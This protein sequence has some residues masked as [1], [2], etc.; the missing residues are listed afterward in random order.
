MESV[1]QTLVQREK[2]N[3][4][5]VQICWST[6][7]IK[8]RDD[9]IVDKKEAEEV[10]QKV[11]G[12]VSA[13]MAKALEIYDTVKD[14]EYYNGHYWTPLNKDD[15]L[16]PYQGGK[17]LLSIRI[18]DYF[19]EWEIGD[20]D[21]ELDEEEEEADD[22]RRDTVKRTPK[23]AQASHTSIERVIRDLADILQS[24]GYQRSPIKA[25][26][27]QDF[28]QQTIPTQRW[29]LKEAEQDTMLRSILLSNAGALKHIV[30][31]LHYDSLWR[32]KPTKV[33]LHRPSISFDH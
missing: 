14:L 2:S 23:A 6:D 27:M 18:P 29:V 9:I 20:T 3:F 25:F 21:D 24:K 28:H 15:H 12:D 19:E 33:R 13:V 17:K 10:Y 30:H 32:P 22:D 16:L 31:C 26:T 4:V 5:Y 1:H 11:R 7:D 8:N